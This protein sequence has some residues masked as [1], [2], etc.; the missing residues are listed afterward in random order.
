MLRERL[1]LIGIILLLLGIQFRRVE[2]YTLTAPVSRIV[3]ERM[4]KARGGASAL[5]GIK[6]GYDSYSTTAMT[7]MPM[8]NAGGEMTFSPPRW[9]GFSFVSVGAVLILTCPC[10]RS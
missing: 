9:L 10:F 7:S 2:S 6:G 8:L 5:A 3:Q 4:E 1:F